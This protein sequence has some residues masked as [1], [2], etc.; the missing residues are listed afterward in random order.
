MNDIQ[1]IFLDLGGTFRIVHENKPYS[2][3]AKARI[4]ELVGTDMSPED[5]HALIETRYEEYRKWALRFMCESPMPYL[6]SRWLAFDCDRERVERNAAEL[7]YQYRRC[8]GERLVV[9]GGVETVRELYAR[10][11]KL[12]IISDLIGCD[13]VD[14]WLD[15]DNLRKYFCAVRQ[16]SITMLRKPHPAIYY[17]A[18]EDAKVRPENCCFVGDN[19][20]RDIVGAKAAGFGATVAVDY[21]E[22]APLKLTDENRP[23]AI[24]HSFSELLEVFP[25]APKMVIG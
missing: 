7:T 10:G 6:W 20:N 1:A 14:E 12:G 16:S 21:P 24:V 13:E 11:Y 5:F 4:A 19:L 3:A 15:N 22:A 25:K 8:K 9:D 18:A 23:N 17:L 2:D